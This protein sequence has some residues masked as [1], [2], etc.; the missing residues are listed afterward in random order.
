MGTPRTP[1]EVAARLPPEQWQVRVAAADAEAERLELA[2]THV[3]AG[4]SRSAVLRELFPDKRLPSMIRRLRRYETGGR[5]GL[6]DL[7]PFLRY[8]RLRIN[9][10]PC[11]DC[12][13][14]PILS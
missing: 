1:A 7:L 4:R 10:F 3:R 8:E 2:L 11:R 9:I 12:R 5:D 6:L 14:S 13:R